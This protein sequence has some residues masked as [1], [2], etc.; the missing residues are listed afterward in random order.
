MFVRDKTELDLG[1][2]LDRRFKT[3]TLNTTGKKYLTECVVSKDN[4]KDVIEFLAKYVGHNS[5]LTRYKWL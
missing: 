5:N 2:I 4:T 3:N 1:V